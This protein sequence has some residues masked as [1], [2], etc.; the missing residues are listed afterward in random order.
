M[1]Y[2]GMQFVRNGAMLNCVYKF[3]IIE[4]MNINRLNTDSH[5]FRF[6][7]VAEKKERNVALK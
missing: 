2:R 4:L 3:S 6:Y 7:R 5:F 1:H